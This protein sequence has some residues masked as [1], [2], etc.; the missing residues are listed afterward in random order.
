[1]FSVFTPNL[2]NTIHKLKVKPSTI[3]KNFSC[4]ALQDEDRPYITYNQNQ[5]EYLESKKSY[6]LYM[7]QSLLNQ[8]TI[9]VIGY[10]AQGRSQAL[11]LKDNGFNVIL[12]LREMGASWD[13]AIEDGWVP[14]QDLYDINQASKKGDIIKYLLSDAGQ[15]EQ[16]SIINNNLYPGNTLYFSHGFGIYYQDYTNIVP[17]DDVNVVMVA[18]KCSGRTVRQNFINKTGFNSSYAI[19]QDV[20]DAYDTTMA[21]AFGIGN[22]LLFETTFEKEVLSDLTGERCI[23]MGMIQAAFSAQYKVLRSHGHSPLEAYNETVE[24]ALES[25]Y[26]IINENGM[27]WL[28]ANCSTTAQRGALDWAPKF[29]EKLIPMIEECYKCVEN[30]TEVKNVIKANSDHQY[31]KK[32]NKELE[33]IANQELWRVFRQIRALERKTMEDEHENENGNVHGNENGNEHENKNKKPDDWDGF[34]L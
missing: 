28:Y 4:A 13:K 19:Y 16:W 34:L 6:P 11:N 32:L 10:G 29:E 30:E 20:G 26:P 15:I 8:N 22:N 33:E 17:P 24:E 9:S 27:D 5:H 1:M 21:L 2:R 25:L 23:L 31:R 7:C 3:I 12:G 18:P 14:D